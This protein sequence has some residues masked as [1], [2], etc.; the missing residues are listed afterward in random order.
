MSDAHPL[1]VSVQPS[2][3]LETLDTF[4]KLRGL[5]VDRMVPLPRIVI[6]GDEGLGRDSVLAAITKI[7][8]PTRG[9]F[10]KQYS[11]ELVLRKTPRSTIKA[12]IL[13]P[14]G[15]GVTLRA[16]TDAHPVPSLLTD[17]VQ[18]AGKVM[19]RNSRGEIEQVLQIEISGP[20][21]PQLTLVDLHNT[22]NH[23]EGLTL[24]ER[25][26]KRYL[27]PT[28]S[29][30]L[31]VVEAGHEKQ[32]VRAI[33]KAQEYD[34]HGHR[35]LGVV[36]KP[37]VMTTDFSAEAVV[38]LMRDGH[39]SYALDLGW[40]VL[41]RP[42]VADMD[43]SE[44]VRNERER[45]ILDQTPWN[46]L[47]GAVRGVACLRTKI[48]MIFVQ[49]TRQ[50]LPLLD[51]RVL[52]EIGERETRLRIFERSVSEELRRSLARTRCQYEDICARALEGVYCGDFFTQASAVGKEPQVRE[53]RSLVQDLNRV[54]ADVMLAKGARRRIT[55]PAEVELPGDHDAV[56]REHDEQDGKGSWSSSKGDRDNAKGIGGGSPDSTRP[57]SQLARAYVFDRP[58]AVTAVRLIEK[59]RADSML[60]PVKQMQLLGDRALDFRRTE[61]Y[62]LVRQLFREQI[63]P[64]E[65]IAIFHVRHVASFAE[66][67][68]DTLMRHILP[69]G[70][71]GF[72]A[73]FR[74]RFTRPF[75][76]EGVIA[77]VGKVKELMYH[78]RHGELLSQELGSQALPPSTRH[79]QTASTVKRQNKDLSLSNDHS[80][81]L[82][83]SSIYKVDAKASSSLSEAEGQLDAEA[84]DILR[85]YE[86]HYQTS[87][88]FFVNNVIVL[89]LENCL[90]TKL[91]S[92][93]TREALDALSDEEVRVLATESVDFRA[94]RAELEAGRQALLHAAKIV[95]DF[96]PAPLADLSRAPTA[97]NHTNDR[98]SAKPVTADDQ[99]GNDNTQNQNTT[100][101]EGPAPVVVVT[102]NGLPVRVRLPQGT[103]SPKSLLDSW[104]QEP[105][106][107]FRD[108]R[109]LAVDPSRVEK[110]PPLSLPSLPSRVEL[111][112]PARPSAESPAVRENRTNRVLAA[113][114]SAALM[115]KVEPPRDSNQKPAKSTTAR[116]YIYDLPGQQPLPE[117]TLA[118]ASLPTAVKLYVATYR[119]DEGRRV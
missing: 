25:L 95:G 57:A 119:L 23:T 67:F 103:A 97:R 48:S 17:I 102:R 99:G 24:V 90:F 20:Y 35:T 22:G 31:C 34:E 8:L 10:S 6:I 93:I 109:R 84:L 45:R 60:R 61:N 79:S 12:Q 58:E 59:L 15:S 81:P 108:T 72:S 44:E 114:G 98:T 28:T 26:E 51:A 37:R 43:A 18:E 66:K 63:A 14:D 74:T 11:L 38:R 111:T 86:S 36:M 82:R 30:V 50:C 106:N 87:L 96:K 5:G 92:L 104:L 21:M 65:H 117:A 40:H 77:L 70:D 68:V 75:F 80:L 47:R 41:C 56:H 54:F 78:H 42:E 52:R 100:T 19:A 64:W 32:M 88:S 113:Q 29:I 73:A 76:D 71:A 112:P 116:T 115:P 46:T 89:A 16:L 91:P 69:G 3:D 83:L 9:L 105:D 13:G 94:R 62:R 53:L 110:P 27:D 55:L 7:P 4:D 2:S 107:S 39:P 101:F 49:H 85:R 118:V 33:S 1:Q